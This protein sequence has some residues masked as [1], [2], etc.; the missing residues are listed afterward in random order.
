MRLREAEIGTGP[1]RVRYLGDGESLSFL[2]AVHRGEVRL[3][4]RAGATRIGEWV[5]DARSQ[6]LTY[7]ELNRL[8]APLVPR[9]GWVTFP[10]VRQ[11]I[12]LGG[13]ALAARWRSIEATY[14]RKVRQNRFCFRVERGRAVA[15]EFYWEFYRPHIQVRYGGAAHLRT[16]AEVR[17]AVRRGFV[18]KVLEDD[19]W[20]AAAACRLR[21]GRV[22]TLAFGVRQG[23][24]AALRRGAL[25]AVY[26]FLLGWARERALSKVDLLRSRPHS[27]DGVFEHKRRF[28]AEAV[29]D[30]WPHTAIWVFPAEG[31]PLPAAAGGLLVWSGT[32]FCPLADSL[33]QLHA[34]QAGARA[35]GGA[36]TTPR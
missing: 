22:T 36:S 29:R 25:S 13:P 2:G 23:Q 7:L 18:L 15:D 20:L 5:Q 30:M 33:G 28:G 32:Q 27:E 35:G 17:S 9:G 1:T 12:D 31:Q 4:G 8:L 19:E 6:G 21:G 10:W 24:E 3:T 26:Y 11:V 16:A 14:G 34:P